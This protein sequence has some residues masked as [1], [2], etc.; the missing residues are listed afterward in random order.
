ME[1]YASS[2]DECTHA[3]TSVLIIGNL[4]HDRMAVCRCLNCHRI[5]RTKALAIY[6]DNRIARR[7]YQEAIHAN[8]T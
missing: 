4:R 1:F 5:L 7:L 6:Y 3:R 2:P 8:Q